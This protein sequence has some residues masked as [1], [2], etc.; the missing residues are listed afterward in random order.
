MGLRLSSLHVADD[1][2]GPQLR[3]TNGHCNRIVPWRVAQ[4]HALQELHSLMSATAEIK[5]GIREHQLTGEV[6]EYA[7]GDL[8]DRLAHMDEHIAD[9]YQEV[10]H[11][12]I[13]TCSMS[14][15]TEES[16]PRGDPPWPDIPRL[17]KVCESTDGHGSGRRGKLQR[18]SAC[19]SVLYC[20]KACQQE[21]LKAHKRLCHHQSQ[22]V[23]PHIV[24]TTVSR[25]HESEQP[26]L[27]I[28]P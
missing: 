11:T 27:T 17:C 6:S 26:Q 14:N 25:V 3:P 22:R 24:T 28:A 13:D 18:C 2:A 23:A 7:A 1:A 16:A 4:D 12:V 9:L 5:T 20:G 8:F 15:P 10:D 19:R 21:D